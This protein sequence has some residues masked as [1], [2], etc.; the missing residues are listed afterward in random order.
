MQTISRYERLQEQLARNAEQIDDLRVATQA[1]TELD[2]GK[3]MRLIQQR[4]RILARINHE[5][6]IS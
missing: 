6:A 4:D 2:R 3:W 5:V 1:L